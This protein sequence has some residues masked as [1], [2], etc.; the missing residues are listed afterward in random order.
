MDF[1]ANELQISLTDWKLISDA[2]ATLPKR[3]DHTFIWEDEQ[4]DY[5]GAHLRIIATVS[6]DKISHFYYFLHV[7]DSFEQK[8]KW[9]RAQNRALA[10]VPIILV[11]LFA[12]SIPVIFLRNWT[13]GQ[14]RVKFA[15][16]C[17]L[18]GA[19][20]ALITSLDHTATI[21][22]GTT[23]WSME[24]FLAKHFIDDVGSALMTGAVCAIFAGAIEVVYRHWYVRQV[25]FELLFSQ[26]RNHFD[27]SP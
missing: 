20:V 6:G 12:L 13:R 25:S 7:P 5:K 18:T 9:L 23:N 21:I 3:T 14:L 8:F 11:I 27:R 2:M 26:A 22:V 16:M 10:N 19:T 4:R 15:V 24:A 1:A 17:G